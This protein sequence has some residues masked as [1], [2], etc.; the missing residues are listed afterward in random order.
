MAGTVYVARGHGGSAL[1]AREGMESALNA[2]L[3]VV[4]FPEGT[5]SDGSGLLKFHGGLLAQG[6]GGDMHLHFHGPSDGP[7]VERW[8]AALMA[9]NPGVVRNMLRSNALTPRTI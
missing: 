3:P 1:K 5:T 2:G 4:F 7:A 6:G 9:R 8:F